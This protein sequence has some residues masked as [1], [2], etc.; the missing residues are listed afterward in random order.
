MYL[1]TTALLFT[2]VNL[3][4]HTSAAPTAKHDLEKEM[5]ASG[6]RARFTR[7]SEQYNN[8]YLADDSTQ[9]KRTWPFA[10]QDREDKDYGCSGGSGSG[11]ESGEGEAGVG[12]GAGAAGS[13]KRI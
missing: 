1:P 10:T 8:T 13:G 5:R 7:T 6:G 3:S 9:K 11:N 12:A 2:L 4:T